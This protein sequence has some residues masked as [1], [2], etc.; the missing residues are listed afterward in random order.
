MTFMDLCF[1][2]REAPFVLHSILCALERFPLHLLTKLN[3]LL[4]LAMQSY[5]TLRKNELSI[6]LTQDPSAQLLAEI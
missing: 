5:Y 1:K 6:I 3:F 2:K 4:L